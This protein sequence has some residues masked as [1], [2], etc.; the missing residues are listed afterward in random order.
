MSGCSCLEESG[1]HG[2]TAIELL[3][4]IAVLAIVTAFAVPG[5]TALV[6]RNRLAAQANE[7]VGALNYARSEAVTRGQAV[8]LCPAQAPYAACANSS[9][10]TG[11]WVVFAD[12]G[13]ANAIDDAADVLRV[14]DELQGGSTLNSHQVQVVRYLPNGF[15]DTVASPFA[16]RAGHCSGNDVRSIRISPQGRP[17]VSVAAC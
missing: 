8:A 2:Y 12:A 3:V 16:L 11:G 7:F 1:T 14:F 10:W 13:V 9:S 4:T 5:M 17:L 6:V 15:L